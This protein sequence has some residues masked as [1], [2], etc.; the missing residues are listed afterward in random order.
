MNEIKY[1]EVMTGEEYNKLR[2]SVDWKPLTEGQ[3]KRGLEH[4]T[5]LVVARDGEM[6]VGMGRV[7]FDY[8]YTA[9][10][11]DVI[12]SPEYQGKGIG[13]CIIENLIQKVM[14]ASEAGDKIMFIMG[15]A[16][17]KEGF[18]EKMGFEVRPNEFAG[19]GMTKWVK[20]N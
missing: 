19:P 15:S 9:Y 5:F 13:K 7:L 11:G 20:V 14:N 10:I 16:K 17:G 12:I 18:Y 1:T 4:T 3:A 8:G 2:V 6:A